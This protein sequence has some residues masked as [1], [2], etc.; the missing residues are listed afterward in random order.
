MEYAVYAH[1][2][3]HI[4]IDNLQFMLSSQAKQTDLCDIQNAAV[5]AFRR[6]AT[7]RNVHLSVVVHPRKE[8]PSKP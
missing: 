8:V 1:D 7:Q 4:I 3:G 2:V 5:A 6:F